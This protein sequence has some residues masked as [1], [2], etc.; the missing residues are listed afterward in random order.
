MT[1]WRRSRWPSHAWGRRGCSTRLGAATWNWTT[2]LRPWTTEVED[3]QWQ[4]N[5]SLLVTQSEGDKEAFKEKNY[6]RNQR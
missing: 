6:R 5:A 2:T 3:D 1:P 4:L